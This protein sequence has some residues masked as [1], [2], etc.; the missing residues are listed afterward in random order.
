MPVSVTRYLEC[1]NGQD[2]EALGATLTDGEFERVGP[3]CDVISDKSAYLRFLAGI[4]PRL[5]DYAVRT[6]RIS[7]CGGVVHAE[8]DETFVLDGAVMD[9]PEVLVFDLGDDGRIA[10]VQVY[11]MRPGES[12]PVPGGKAGPAGGGPA[13]P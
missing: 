9:F 4:V 7:V 5:A 3:Y 1:L 8:V 2:W 13:R 6:R 10:R 12:S 11:M